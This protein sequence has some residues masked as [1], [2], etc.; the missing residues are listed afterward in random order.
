MFWDPHSTQVLSSTLNHPKHETL[1]GVHVEG[2]ALLALRGVSAPAAAV[3]RAS[4]ATWNL[5]V[6]QAFGFRVKGLALT[7]VRVQIQKT[8][9]LRISIL[10]ALTFATTCLFFQVRRWGHRPK[11]V[12]IT[13]SELG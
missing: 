1:N 6:S 12:R 10:P 9:L 11:Q 7:I 2:L 4:L 13:Y 3:G 8:D 5:G